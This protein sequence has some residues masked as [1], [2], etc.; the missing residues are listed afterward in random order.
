MRVSYKWLKEY[1]DIPVSPGDLADRLTLAGIAVEGVHQQGAGIEKVYTGKILAIEPHPNADRLTVCKVTAG[2]PE[3]L[4]IV[5]G[6]TN[7][8]TGDVIPVAVEGAHLAG[9]L[10][11]KKS[12]LRGVE[13]RGMLCSG[14][15]LG[16]DPKTMPAEQAHGIMILSPDTQLG[17]DIKPVIGLDDAV[18]ELDLTPNRGDAMS[19]V[20]VAREV[21][22]LLGQSLRLPVLDVEESGES[23]GGKV[24]IDIEDGELCRRYVAKVFTGI[25][26]GPSPGWMQERLRAAGVRPISNLVDITNYVMMELGQPLHAFDYDTLQDGHIIVRRAMDG[27]V[28]VSLDGAKRKLNRDMLVI[29]DPGGPVAVAGVMGGL[30][31]EVTANTRNVLLESAWFNPIS[32]RKTSKALGL[33]SES[34]S[35]FEKGID[36][37]G[38]LRAAR[39]A[40]R[41]LADMGAGVVAP[42]EVDNYP[43]PY[44]PKTIVLRPER[45]EH[46]L[47][48]PVSA[49][50]S[51]DILGS[52]EFGVQKDGAGLMVTVPGHRPD[53]SLEVDLIEEVAR[54]YGYNRIPVTLPSGASTKGGRTREQSLE[55]AVKDRMAAIGLR[56]VIT[57]TFISP[58]AFTNINL[59][60][61]S[62]L[63]QVMSLQNP[64]SEEQSVM[65][66]TILPGLLEVLHRNANRK[67]TNLSIF[68]LGKVYLPGGSDALP[69]ERPVLAAAAMGRTSRG[70]N[71]PALEK[72]FY[73]MKG[74]LETLLRQSGVDEIYYE[75]LKDNPSYHPGRAA[76][77]TAA[78]SLL[79]IIGEVHPGVLDNYELPNR[80]VAM[81]IDFNVLA[82]VSG[83]AG[84]Y[85]Q[86][87]RF[88][89]IE[90]DLAVVVSLQVPVRDIMA[91]IKKAGG[92]L[93]REIELFDV[94]RGEQVKQDCQSLAFSLTF[95]AD[96]RT[97]TEDEVS[98]PLKAIQENMAGK[99]EAQLRN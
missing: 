52:L 29:A 40:S 30:A 86:L 49:E 38:C 10:V 57:Y 5:T 39:R 50:D 59:P 45:V 81:E 93:L 87:P 66:T 32:I 77:V 47:G 43:S 54:I 64:L 71:R 72:D 67:I 7:I 78:G 3:D 1:V 62:P 56:E 21:A 51:A 76:R 88:P 31:T 8:S 13:S 74:V 14:Q 2:G 98:G 15:E 11:I 90:R 35:R 92:R 17:L 44:V 25:K 69:E 75:P 89:G 65:R 53:V 34:S 58:E 61:E 70:W 19:M 9:G 82:A 79:G 85:S 12:K 80:V 33:R 27:D 23:T 94:Y 42:G 26:I 22:A 97:L 91:V 63:R 55:V 6:A 16:L 84:K 37:T 60:P 68:E 46:I 20:G 4:Q 48:T 73:Y 95:R 41:L 96:D 36:L 18:L 24:K 99:F 28:L 83:R